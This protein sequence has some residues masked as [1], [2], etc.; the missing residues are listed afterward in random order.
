[1]CACVSIQTELGELRRN[2]GNGEG[3]NKCEPLV[4]RF[5]L[6]L[7]NISRD[8][9]SRLINQPPAFAR[10]Q[11]PLVADAVAEIE[12]GRRL[13]WRSWARWA[14]QKSNASIPLLE[15]RVVAS[16]RTGGGSDRELVREVGVD[17]S[18]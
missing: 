5:R 16:R 17:T 1:M 9:F 3:A 12:L 13:F 2:V 14:S 10:E 18:R 11:A 7:S 6:I 4:V 8:S 15:P